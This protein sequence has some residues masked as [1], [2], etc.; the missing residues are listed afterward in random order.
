MPA[1]FN[2]MFSKKAFCMLIDECSFTF[3]KDLIFAHDGM[4]NGAKEALQQSLFPPIDKQKL[5]LNDL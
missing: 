2:E 3:A 1:S 4:L 5:L